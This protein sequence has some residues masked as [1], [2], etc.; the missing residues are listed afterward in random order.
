[1]EPGSPY[2]SQVELLVRILPLVARQKCFALKGGTAINLFVR[3]LPRLSVDI[4]VT[5]L[6][7]HPRDEALAAMDA[8]LRA[9]QSDLEKQLPGMRVV[10]ATLAGTGYYYKLVAQLEA[11]QV[12]I[13][14]S[15]VMRG[16]VEP[17]VLMGT[18]AQTRLTFGYVQVP[19]VAFNDLYAGKL[20]AALSRQHPRDLFDVAILLR[21]E[22][23]NEQFLEVFL[24]YLACSN[25][26]MAELLDPVKYELDRG[27]LKNFQG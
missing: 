16:V 7:V 8:A 25:R 2:F 4:D 14:V 3:D 23:L 6:P 13:E 24:V 17:S 19:V 9:L 11:V 22:G 21:N 1:M 26:P 27:L 15:P 5:Y 12:K 18:S 10:G 20:C